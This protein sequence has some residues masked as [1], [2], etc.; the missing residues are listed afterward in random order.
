MADIKVGDKVKWI[1]PMMAVP[2]PEG[3]TDRK[4]VVLP[5]FRDTERIGTV[6]STHGGGRNGYSLRP[7]SVIG[8]S[9]KGMDTYYDVSVAVDGITKI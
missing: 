4:G 1:T 9:P 6:I 3:K 5:V 7:D 8:K 2:H